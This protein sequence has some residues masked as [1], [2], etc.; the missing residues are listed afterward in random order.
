MAKV[1]KTIKLK[2]DNPNKGKESALF[3]TVSI[4][5]KVLATYIDFTL[6]HRS[7]F[8][9]TKEV[10]SKK[11]GEVKIRKLNNLEILTEVEKHTF[12]TI[13]HPK[14][15]INVKTIY[16]NLPTSFRRSCI[17]TSTGMCKSYLS[18]LVSFKSRSKIKRSK[19]P[20]APPTPKNLPTFY[21]GTYKIELLDIMNQFV[22]LKVYHKGEWVFINYPI[23]IGKKQLSILQSG[24]WDILSPTLVPKKRRGKIE[25]YLHIPVEK[26]VKVKPI[27]EQKKEDPNL[28]TLSIDMG[29]KHIA[30]ITVR[31]GGKIV[32]VNFFRSEQ[33]EAHRLRHLQKIFKKQK[34]SGKAVKG[35]RSD[36]QLW[37]HISEMNDAYAHLVSTRIIEIAKEYSVDVIIIEYLRKFRNQRREKRS[38]KFNRKFT[39]WLKGKLEFNLRYKALEH[40]ILVKSVNPQETSQICNKCGGFGERFSNKSSFQCFYCGYV[41]NADFNASVNLHQVFF[42]T[43]PL[44]KRKKK[45][46]KPTRKRKVAR[47]GVS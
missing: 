24:G 22:R 28:T 21:K 26:K 10:V 11:T 19:N 39:Y 29:L 15:E 4:L 33:I 12:P 14:P 7:L 5:N 16:P 18:S 32:F 42:L 23:K 3:Q 38:K 44:S 40:G 1:V 35:E 41:A 46:Q 45:Q 6:A 30:V 36:K 9:Q 37:K 13:A 2:I 17:N 31:K 25:W 8:S 47:S 43:F 27:E 34:K 20:P